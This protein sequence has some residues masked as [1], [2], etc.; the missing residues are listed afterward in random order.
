MKHNACWF[1][2]LMLSV[3]FLLNVL[4]CQLGLRMDLG[5]WG[6]RGAGCQIESEAIILQRRRVT[7]NPQRRLRSREGTLNW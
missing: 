2:F 3:R 6:R 7:W 5:S 1:W 4:R